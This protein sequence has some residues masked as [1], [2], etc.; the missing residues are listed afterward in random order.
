MNT[1]VKSEIISK[2]RIIISNYYNNVVFNIEKNISTS[3]IGEFMLCYEIINNVSGRIKGEDELAYDLYQENIRK[4]IS[5]QFLLNLINLNDEELLINLRKEW[6]KFKIFLYIMNQ[7]FSKIEKFITKVKIDKNFTG[8]AFDFLKEICFSQL[9]DKLNEIIIKLIE[10]DRNEE[11][12]NS[13]VLIYAIN[14][15]FKFKYI[16]FS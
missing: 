2:A 1:A 16:F 14:V 4:Y 12:I 8:L 3:T 13:D 10:K 15:I 11:I 9:S 6:S 7:I 5:D